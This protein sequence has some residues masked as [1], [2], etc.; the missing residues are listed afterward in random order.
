[1]TDI[2]NLFMESHTT[3]LEDFLDDLLLL[4]SKDNPSIVVVRAHS[5]PYFHS[6]HDQSSQVGMIVDNYVQHL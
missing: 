2:S 4:F 1:M 5:D 6:V 3:D